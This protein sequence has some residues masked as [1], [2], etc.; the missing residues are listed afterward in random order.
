VVP[1]RRC[2][3]RLIVQLVVGVDIRYLSFK[4]ESSTGSVM[5]L[6]P[7][8]RRLTEVMKA[9]PQDAFNPMRSW[10]G[11]TS[12]G[13]CFSSDKTRFRVCAVGQ[14]STSFTNH[15]IILSNSP[16]GSQCD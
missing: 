12:D 5:Q 7:Q 16:L 2:P 13:T 8:A 11:A 6:L 9:Y 3:N 14:L 4:H 10:R 1:S 15:G